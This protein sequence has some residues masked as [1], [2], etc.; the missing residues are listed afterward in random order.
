MAKRRGVWAELQRERA[1]KQR[2][3]QQAYRASVQAAKKAEREREQAQRAA[4]RRA[5]QNERERKRLYIEDR[6][7]EAADLAADLRE[8]IEELDSVLTAGVR[9]RPDASFTS[10]KRTLQPPPFDPGGFDRPIPPPQ[11]I[12]P[13]PPGVLGGLLGGRARYAREEAAAR[14]TYER[15]RAQHAAAEADRLRRLE[16]RRRAY[17]QGLATES[18]TVRRHNAEIDKFEQDFRAGDSD[19]V[20]RFFTLI[21]DSSP[22]PEGFPHRTRAIYRTEPRELVVEYELPPQSVIPDERDYKYVQ[23]RDEIDNVA[24]P[25]KETKDRYARLVAQIAL[26]TLHEVFAGDPAAIVK[27]ASFN[28]HVS[29]TDPATGQPVRPCLISV[30]AEKDLFSTFRLA[31]VEPV[32]CLKK[33]NALVSPHPYDLEPVRPVVDF[34]AL[35]SQYKFVEGM[36]A[37]AGLDARSDLLDMTPTEFEHLVRQLFEA[38]GMK[39]WAT[40]ASKDDGVD[41]VAVNEDP[42][43]G[44]L[45]VIQAKRYRSAVGVEPVRALAGVMED[46]HAT[47]GIMVTTSW[48]TKEGHAF[49]ARHGRIQI[50]E[51]EEIKYLCKEHLDLDVLISLPKPPPK[52]R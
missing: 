37:V 24:R 48:V 1:R 3:A 25:V 33:L 18:E 19:A 7:A 49:A 27:V 14:Q 31:D 39:S 21:L 20:A 45:C 34:E 43:F 9:R 41:A 51:C 32:A 36:D 46:K 23:S 52:R 13:Q 8:R 12:P 16:G 47:K 15:Q 28:G 30:S 42:V 10:L 2:L 6:K 5:A 35:L 22:Y 11:W 50:M 17:D 4:A 40:Q 44:G 26:R 38:M 29:T